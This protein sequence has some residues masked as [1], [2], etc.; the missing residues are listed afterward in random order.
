M[1]NMVWN[2][3][4]HNIN[5]DK[6]E[7]FNVFN[8]RSFKHYTEKFLK[9]CD[10]KEQFS[11]ELRKELSYYFWCRAEY[12]IVIG[13]WVGGRTDGIKVDIYGQVML[14]W[15]IFVDYVWSFKEAVNK[16]QV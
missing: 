14:N 12:E 4:R 3:Y 8:H 7:V 2:V 6:I 16:K 5:G 13:P 11:E 1:D 10:T 15:E 9:E